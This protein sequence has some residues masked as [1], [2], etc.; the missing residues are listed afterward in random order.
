[1]NVSINHPTGRVN[2]SYV[3]VGSLT[4]VFSY[5]TVI[6]FQQGWGSWVVTVNYWGPTT[7][8]HLNWVSEDKESRLEDD[9]FQAQL[10]VAL[11]LIDTEE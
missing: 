5:Q 2:F 3:Y 4:L 6:A 8:K 11:R 1:M 7:G 9:E 10:K